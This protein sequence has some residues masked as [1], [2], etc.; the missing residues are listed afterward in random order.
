M[1]SKYVKL[2]KEE[3]IYRINQIEGLLE[4]IRIQKHNCARP[5]G[6]FVAEPLNAFH[7]KLFA[8]PSFF[9]EEERD[10][11]L[12]LYEKQ[13]ECRELFKCIALSK[14]EQ[15]NKI[16]NVFIPF[17]ENDLTQFYQ[18]FME[19]DKFYDCGFPGIIELAIKSKEDLCSQLKFLGNFDYGPAELFK[20]G[21]EV[22]DYFDKNLSDVELI[23]VGLDIADVNVY[24]NL[25]NFKSCV[26]ENI[27]KNL[28]D[29]AFKRGYVSEKVNEINAEFDNSDNPTWLQKFFRFIFKFLE[30][31]YK[32][33]YINYSKKVR[34]SF[35][36]D[37][38]NN[39]RINM[40]I[41]NNG[42]SFVGDVNTVFNK[43]TGNGTGLGLYS[44]RDFLEYNDATITMF[45]NTREEY[46]VGFIIN[47]P[48]KNI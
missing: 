15:I 41:E 6:I 37:S 39:D 7:K 10:K 47:L 31:K 2:S 24:M 3:L 8:D 33:K 29:H 1:E 43:N 13:I 11:I 44:A 16:Q 17:V 40:I 46:K 28:H 34:I 26:L 45:T 21:T 36:Q 42:H 27:I 35:E 32:G 12:N 20:L 19:S 9:S 38:Q 25:T 5:L 18:S 23:R 14:K 30:T 48:I 22:R 4:K